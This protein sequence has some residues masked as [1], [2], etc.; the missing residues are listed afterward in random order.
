MGELVLAPLHAALAELRGGDAVREAAALIDVTE[1]QPL[2]EFTK[3]DELAV[4][5]AVDHAGRVSSRT[6]RAGAGSTNGTSSASGRTPTSFALRLDREARATSP[7]LRPPPRPAPRPRHARAAADNGTKPPELLRDERFRRAIG[8]NEHEGTL[9]FN[10]ERFEHALDVLALPRRAEM[11]RAAQRAGYRLD[12]FEKELRRAR[13][14]GPR[15]VLLGHAR[16]Q[17]EDDVPSPETSRRQAQRQEVG[18]EARQEVIDANRRGG[19]GSSSR[20]S[21]RASTT[22]AS[23]RS[24][25]SAMC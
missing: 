11:K 10:R 4:A 17:P 3:A 6:W 1:E 12:L 13:R 14:S 21:R 2:T 9:W 22:G 23:R 24:A 8:V 16:A 7:R 18:H 5:Q 19:A 15:R 25:S 20:T